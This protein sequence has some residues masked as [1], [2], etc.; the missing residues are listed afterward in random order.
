MSEREQHVYDLLLG[1]SF[2]LAFLVFVVLFFVTAPYGRHVRTGWGPTLSNRAGWITMEFPAVAAI[3]VCFWLGNG[4]AG[5]SGWALLALWETHYLYRALVFPF[6]L[7]RGGKRMPVAIVAMAI[8]FNISNGYLNGRYLGLHAEQYTT[9]W[10]RD[11]R[12]LAGAVV[13]FAG[14]GINLHSDRILL[15]LRAPG[16]SGYKV[17]R[18]GMFRWVTSPNYLGEC[19]EWTGWAIAAWSLPGLLFA[20]WTA[21]NLVPRAYAHH[22]WYRE[23]F[24]DYP[25]ERRALIPYLF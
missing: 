11:P 10:L 18:G 21:A 5:S 2:A 4:F 14:L 12:F 7:P 16:E 23:K 20:V 15:R 8:V 6:R 25:E 1:T 24:P 19:V 3:A 22:K 9:A 13:F 17:P